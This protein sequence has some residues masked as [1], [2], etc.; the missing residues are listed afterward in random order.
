[1]KRNLAMIKNKAE[2]FGL[3]FLGNSSKISI[4]PLLNIMHSRKNIPVAVLEIV[5]CQGH[6][7][8]GKKNRLGEF[9][10]NRLLNHMKEIDPTKQLLDTVMFDESSNVQL[11]GRLLNCF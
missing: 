2:I 9:I 4:C 1:M 5:D 10:C 7:A 8:H 11:S 3:L 6:L